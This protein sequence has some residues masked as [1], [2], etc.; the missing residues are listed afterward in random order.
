M[1]PTA[2]V[3]NTA[4]GACVDQVLL[5]GNSLH[6]ILICNTL[7]SFFPSQ[8]ALVTALK[9]GQIQAAGLDVTTPEPLPTDH[10]LFSLPNCVILPHIG[11]A[12]LEC[13]T[14]MSVMA[15]KNIVAVLKGDE[16]MP[17]QVV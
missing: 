7:P 9:T 8:D 10:P 5:Y 12:S 2:I 14:V 4:R 13:R 17:A 15:A 11:S 1:K 6:G 3:I 16:P